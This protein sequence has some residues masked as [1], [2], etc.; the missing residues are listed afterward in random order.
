MAA[1]S[2][3][4]FSMSTVNSVEIT[5]FIKTGECTESLAQLVTKDD[6]NVLGAPHLFTYLNS[7]KVKSFE[8]GILIATSGTRAFDLE[9]RIDVESKSAERSGRETGERGATGV[10]ATRLHRWALK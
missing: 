8:K 6:D 2:V 3:S 9:L 1:D 7:F 5:C 4:K 10:D